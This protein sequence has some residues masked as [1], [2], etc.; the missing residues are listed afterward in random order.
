MREAGRW[1]GRGGT[2]R[3]H[4]ADGASV[5]LGAALWNGQAGDGRVFGCSRQTKVPAAGLAS[6]CPPRGLI[7]QQASRLG[8]EFRPTAWG[9]N[10]PTAEFP[11]AVLQLKSKGCR[12]GPHAAWIL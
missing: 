12:F 7:L 5:A 1:Q 9:A 3:R 8:S 2:G 4:E 6:E 11:T 10:L